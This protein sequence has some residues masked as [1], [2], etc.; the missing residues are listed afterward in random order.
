MI[1]NA[2]NTKNLCCVT[3]NILQRDTKQTP[4][5]RHVQ[6]L[7]TAADRKAKAIEFAKSGIVIPKLGD[8]D[9]RRGMR[10]AAI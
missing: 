1:A 5:A 9:N 6:K 8:Y 3:G 7:Q 10:K 4:Y 2:F